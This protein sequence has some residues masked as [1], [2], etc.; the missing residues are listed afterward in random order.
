MTGT[1]KKLNFGENG[2]VPPD[3]FPGRLRC[4][5]SL[6]QQEKLPECRTSQKQSLKDGSSDRQL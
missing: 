5:C 6:P 2:I 1:K 3:S 4:M